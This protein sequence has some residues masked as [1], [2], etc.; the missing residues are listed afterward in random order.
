MAQPADSAD[1]AATP[2]GPTEPGATPTDWADMPATPNPAN[3]FLRWSVLSI[4]MQPINC[5]ATQCICRAE[6]RRRPSEAV[7]DVDPRH[8]IG[9]PS[10]SQCHD[11]V[12]R[13]RRYRNRDPQ[14]PVDVRRHRSAKGLRGS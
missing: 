7:L 10:S 3:Y 4:Q 11:C 8:Y 2:A 14:M 5:P 6:R 9:S 13:C 1:L 12:Q